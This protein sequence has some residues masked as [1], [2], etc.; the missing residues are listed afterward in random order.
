MAGIGRADVRGDR[1]IH[2]REV[3]RAHELPEDLDVRSLPVS[4]S[5]SDAALVFGG[6]GI[7]S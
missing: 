1:V 3:F 5:P 4:W 2:A 6:L 7:R